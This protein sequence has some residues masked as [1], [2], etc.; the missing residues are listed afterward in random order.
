[1]SR[2]STDDPH[3]ALADDGVLGPLVEAHGPLTLEPA[4]DLYE[5]LARSLL[6]QQVSTEAAAAIEKR[7]R[8]SVAVTPEAILAADPADLRAA[9]LSA[10]KVEYAKAAAETFRE[11]GYDHDYFAGMPDGAVAAEL[12]AIRG[13]G[14]WTAEMFLLFGLGREDVFP[15]GD[16]GIR[17]GMELLFG[18]LTRAAMVEEAERWRPYRSYASLYLWHHY[19]GGDTGVGQH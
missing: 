3:A 13:V 6:R 14:P 18:E 5:R 1:M 7:L 12:T 19:E 11:E 17:R 9:G 16:L 15:V 10:A 2:E 4:S 8:E